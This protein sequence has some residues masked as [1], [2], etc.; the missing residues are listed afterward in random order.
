MLSKFLASAA[1]YTLLSYLATQAT[2]QTYTTCNPL[3]ETCNACPALSGSL[4]T[5]F[6]DGGSSRYEA[7]LTTNKVT[8]TDKGAAFTIS[9]KGDSPSVESDFFIMF[10]HIEFVAQAAPGKG[11]VSSMVL[12]SDDLDEIDL[13]WVGSD[14]LQVQSNYFSKGDTSTYTRGAY[15]SVTSPQSTMNTYAIDWTS[16]R[17]V[18]YINGNAV[19]TLTNSGDGTYPQS[20]MQVRFGSWAGGDPSNNPGTIQWAGGVTDYSAGPY[21]YYVKSIKVQDYSTGSEYK[22]TDHSGSWTSIAAVNGK[23]NG[24]L[25][26][27]A[28]VAAQEHVGDLSSSVSDADHAAD[29]APAPSPASEGSSSSSSSSAAPWKPSSSESSSVSSSTSSASTTVWWTPES[30]TKTTIWWTPSPDPE[31]SSHTT[32]SLKFVGPPS[33]VQGA[34]PAITTLVSAAS[35]GADTSFIITSAWDSAAAVASGSMTF[36]F[37]EGNGKLDSSKFQVVNVVGKN[38]N[39][40]NSNDTAPPSPPHPEQSNDSV[41]KSLSSALMLGSLVLA[42]L[43]VF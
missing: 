36:E 43:L 6:I 40:T 13:E 38:S 10:G 20:P 4:D 9:Q 23:I 29:P 30:Q 42:Y 5:S 7:Y 1:R 2:A 12:I 14:T 41:S 25:G 37:S 15:H 17:I 22:Y 27:S 11:I 8:Y 26:G 18:W 21:V 32:P 35:A 28:G 16:E 19:R 31:V 3:K 39:G 24:N 34:E 33:G